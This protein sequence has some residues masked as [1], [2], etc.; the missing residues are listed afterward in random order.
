MRTKKKRDGKRI[1][2]ICLCVLLS[3]V[4]V[5]MVSATIWLEDMLSM[6]GRNVDNSS[7]SADEYEELFGVSIDPNSGGYVGPLLED[8]DE[9]INI[10]LI[11]QDRR[12]GEGRQ[13][14]DAMILCTFNLKNK[15]LTMTSFMRDMYVAIPGYGSNRINTC[16]QIGGMTL[17][18]ECLK[19]NFGIEVDG[20]IEVDFSGFMTVI[21]SI[22]GLD[23]ELNA[24]EAAYL[25]RRGNWGVDDSTAGQWN[26]KEGVNHLTGEQAL[27]Y[28]RIRYIG[29]ADFERTERQ[30]DVLNALMEECKDMNVTQLNA[31]IREFLPLMTTDLTNAQIISYAM[32]VFPMAKD[33]QVNTCR[34]PADDAYY[35]ADVN[36]M[37]VLMPDLEKS[38]DMLSQM[39][40]D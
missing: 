22:G 16:Y 3:V 5:T 18:D 9:I 17:L 32:W 38:R 27:A 37:S 14:S 20:N 15:S 39:L 2:L 25:N 11:G 31:L 24:D 40:S 34:V 23:I 19:S 21:D 4:L 10:L 30:R 28:S 12:D 26:L 6:L 1:F 7:M 8:G 35:N 13:R 33:L 36:G 29:N